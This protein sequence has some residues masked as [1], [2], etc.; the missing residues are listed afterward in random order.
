[1]LV[2]I[3]RPIVHVTADAVDDG[4]ARTFAEQHID[5]R[6]FVFAAQK[7]LVAFHFF[8]Q[9]QHGHLRTT[10]QNT[11]K[12]WKT[13]I[14]EVLR[15][16]SKQGRDASDKIQVVQIGVVGDIDV[17]DA[18]VAA[19]SAPPEVDAVA[20]RSLGSNCVEK[21]RKLFMPRKRTNLVNT[22]NFKIGSSV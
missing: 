21:V 10:L 9:I 17:A 15:S 4:Q 11:Q 14:G 3:P 5:Q 13:Q 22:K 6:S 16:Y 7:L 12:V 19:P 20:G 8:R 2:N 1:M 18:L